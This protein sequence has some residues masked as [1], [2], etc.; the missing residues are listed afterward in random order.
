M[1]SNKL[2]DLLKR[3][4]SAIVQEWFDQV[5][6]TYST[7]TSVFLKKERDIFSNPVG[8]ALRQGLPALFDELVNGINREP[9][10]SFL[11]PII[12]I[13]AIQNFSPSQ[14]ISFII[15]LKKIIRKHLSKELTENLIIKTFPSFES[16]IDELI[17][18]AFDIYMECREMLLDIKSN[19]EKNK[20]LKTFKRAGLIYEIPEQEPDNSV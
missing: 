10:I 18:M 20:V 4:K 16:K 14:V 6:D 13:R 19:D 11:D 15:D 8:D 2:E 17:L 1:T 5:A 3:K 7:E 9:A 12:R